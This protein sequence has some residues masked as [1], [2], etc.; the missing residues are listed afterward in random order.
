MSS[1][2][3]SGAGPQEHLTLTTGSRSTPLGFTEDD[4]GVYLVAKDRTAQWP[5]FALREGKVSLTRH[6]SRT[7]SGGVTLISD[8]EDRERILTL[9]RAKY[10]EAQFER[11]Y[12]RPARVLRVD[13]ATTSPTGT[14]VADGQYQRWLVAEFD[15]IAH[16]YDRHILGNRMNVLLRD[17]SLALMRPLFRSNHLLM[18]VGCGSGTETMTLLADGHEL[19]AVDISAQML[20]VVREKA[21]SQ[22][23]SEQLRT[24]HL[25]AREVGALEK[26]LGIESLDGAYSTYGALDRKSVV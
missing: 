23:C 21:R 9:F 24:F 6:G 25:A 16:E 18:E 17:R 10:G 13:V 22:G 14:V 15:G 1:E 19:I 5:I 20:E 26:E 8:R 4:R 11:W 12:S 3:A 7:A 2:A